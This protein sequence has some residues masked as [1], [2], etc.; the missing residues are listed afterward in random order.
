MVSEKQ[1]TMVETAE[2]LFHALEDKNLE[3]FTIILEELES[4]FK[5]GADRYIL[6]K[7]ANI[8]SPVLGLMENMEV[9]AGLY[10][11]IR[12]LLFR[13]RLGVWLHMRRKELG[14]AVRELASSAQVDNGYVSRIERGMASAPSSKILQKLVDILGLPPQEIRDLMVAPLAPPVEVTNLLNDPLARKTLTEFNTL[15]AEMREL[16][17]KYVNTT[18]AWTKKRQQGADL[19]LSGEKWANLPFAKRKAIMDI[20]NILVGFDADTLNQAMGHISVLRS[21]E[22]KTRYSNLIH[23]DFDRSPGSALNIGEEE[24]DEDM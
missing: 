19:A 7:V 20:V 14:F 10:P 17:F 13:S 2:S 12:N 16:I 23:S 21:Q 5:Q 3:E 4:A 22:Q 9:P 6:A 24:E 1:D 15:P 18:L 11:R 8:L